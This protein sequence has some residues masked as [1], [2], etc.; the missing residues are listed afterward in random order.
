[1]EERQKMKKSVLLMRGCCSNRVTSFRSG[2]DSQRSCSFHV[3]AIPRYA[4][5]NWPVR[6]F[7]CILTLFLYYLPPYRSVSRSAC[8]FLNRFYILF[9]M[10][11]KYTRTSRYYRK[12][13]TFFPVNIQ[14]YTKCVKY[15]HTLNIFFF[16]IRNKVRAE[17]STYMCRDAIL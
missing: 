10:F 13:T 5:W 17:V 3:T 9:C 15:S 16:F 14:N 11:C 7:S 2:A 4:R 6:N 8:F 1:M 12:T